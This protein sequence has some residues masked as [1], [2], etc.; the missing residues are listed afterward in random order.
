MSSEKSRLDKIGAGTN[1]KYIKSFQLTTEST[2]DTGFVSSPAFRQYGSLFCERVVVAS[3]G[4]Y[5]L[6]DGVGNCGGSVVLAH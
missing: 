2:G 6:A 5:D 4:V 3:Q 1:D